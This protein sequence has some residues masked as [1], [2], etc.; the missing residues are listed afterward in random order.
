MKLIALAAGVLLA[1]AP[2][3]PAWAAS[4][5]VTAQDPQSVLSALEDLGYKGDL[6]K[7]DNGRAQIAITVKNSPTYIDFY[8]CDDKMADCYTLLFSYGMN[9][10]KGTTLTKANEWNTREI[11]GRIWLDED[12]DPW[13][14]YAVVTYDGIPS[15]TFSQVMQI[16]EH[17]VETVKEFFDF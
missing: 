8:N 12:D 1:V 9:L 3:V 6:S 11:N 5:N 2:A 16:W 17:Q 10:S 7:R 4:G 13:L 14:D 15:G